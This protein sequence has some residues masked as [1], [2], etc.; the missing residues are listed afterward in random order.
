[1]GIRSLQRQGCA[2]V[3]IPNSFSTSEQFLRLDITIEVIEQLRVY[4]VKIFADDDSAFDGTYGH[5]VHH[6]QIQ[7]VPYLF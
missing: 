5:N 7:F 2:L 3:F 4:R 1:M 6:L